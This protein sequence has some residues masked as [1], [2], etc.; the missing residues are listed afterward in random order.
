MHDCEENGRKSSVVPN[1]SYIRQGYKNGDDITAHTMYNNLALSQRSGIP[2]D[3]PSH[4][5]V[6][7]IGYHYHPSR[8]K[9]IL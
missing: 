4:A 7:V 1:P 3:K 9:E 6:R 5:I 2:E 8:T